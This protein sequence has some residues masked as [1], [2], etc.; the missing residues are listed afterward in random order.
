MRLWLAGNLADTSAMGFIFF[1][2]CP[3][4]SFSAGGSWSTEGGR[5]SWPGI[6]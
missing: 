6:N 5:T 3:W 4:Q 2:F 1:D